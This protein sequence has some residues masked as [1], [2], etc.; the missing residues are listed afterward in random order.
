MGRYLGFGEKYLQVLA[1]P[2]IIEHLDPRPKT[3]KQEA[4]QKAILLLIHWG[5]T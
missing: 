4:A 1:K 3:L 5:S 2:A